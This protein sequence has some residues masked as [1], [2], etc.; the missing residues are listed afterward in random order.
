MENPKKQADAPRKQIRLDED[1]QIG[2]GTYGK[3]FHVGHLEGVDCVVKVVEAWN[4]DQDSE[5]EEEENDEK[6][7]DIGNHHVFGREFLFPALYR[8]SKPSG[9]P[10]RLCPVF[11]S[12]FRD[13]KL[14]CILPHRGADLED[15]TENLRDPVSPPT[16]RIL[17]T[18]CSTPWPTSRTSSP[19]LCMATSSQQICW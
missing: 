19:R 8:R 13:A 5:E 3:V 2:E 4:E 11:Q 14:S 7:Q 6:K 9:S 12:Q 15:L 17:L 10:W 16:V 1:N 18:R